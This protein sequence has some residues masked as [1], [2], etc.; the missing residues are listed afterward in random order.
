MFICQEHLLQHC[1][2][3]AQWSFTRFVMSQLFCTLVS[4]F[5]LCC[6]CILLY[7]VIESKTRRHWKYV[8]DFD[9]GNSVISISTSNPH[10][11]LCMYVR[12]C[13]CVTNAIILQD[14]SITLR[15]SRSYKTAL[16]LLTSVHYWCIYPDKYLSSNSSQFTSH[17]MSHYMIC[18]LVPILQWHPY[19]WLGICQLNLSPL[20]C[21]NPSFF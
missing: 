10:G 15:T 18:I 20:Q 7:P 8:F 2:R 21:D 14:D 19:W 11:C 17:S 9:I 5:S 16:M 3:W 1:S 12:N 13:T 4:P 6:L